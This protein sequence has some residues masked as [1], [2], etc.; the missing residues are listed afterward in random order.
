M[1][2]LPKIL[3]VIAILYAIVST[4]DYNDFVLANETPSQHL[5]HFIL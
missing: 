4:M 1:D 2:T 5:S 3:I